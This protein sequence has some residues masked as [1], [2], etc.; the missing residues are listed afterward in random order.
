MCTRSPWIQF[1]I[2]TNATYVTSGVCIGAHMCTCL[3]VCVC[4]SPYAHASLGVCGS[5]TVG[6]FG[7]GTIFDEWFIRNPDNSGWA[8]RVTQANC[9]PM[10]EAFGSS[11]Q[12]DTTLFYWD[13]VVGIP[14]P[15]VFVPPPNCP[16]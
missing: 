4:V 15:D 3:C 10:F 16:Q 11:I 13:T 7:D 12:Y 8:M 5:G 6:I 1:Q 9:I 14:D 2:P